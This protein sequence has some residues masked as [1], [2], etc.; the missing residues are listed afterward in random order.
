MPYITGRRSYARETYPE[1]PGS[2]GSGTTGPTGPTGPGGG[3]DP[4]FFY[5]GGDE[6]PWVDNGQLLGPWS[7]FGLIAALEAS[8]GS[9]V[10]PR[11]GTIDRLTLRLTTGVVVGDWIAVVRKNFVDTALTGTIASGTAGPNITGNTISVV[12]G[13]RISIRNDSVST[14]PAGA[15]IQAILDFTPD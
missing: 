12:A 2:G 7:Q 3:V 14:I 13:D 10:V 8:A 9:I 6:G 15:A 4:S 11:N 1:R 5:F